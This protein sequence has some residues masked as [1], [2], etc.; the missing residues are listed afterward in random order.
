MANRRMISSSTWKDE[1]VGDLDFFQRCLWIGLF[2][3]CADDQGRLLDNS[4]LIRAELFPY[5]DIPAVQIEDGLAIFEKQG[6]ILRYSIKNKKYIQILKWWENQNP[7]WASRSKFPPPEG[8]MDKVRTRENGKYLVENWGS[9]GGMNDDSIS[10]Y[11]DVYKDSH[12]DTVLNQQ[13]PVPVPDPVKN[14]VPVPDVNKQEPCQNFYS[15]FSQ[16]LQIPLMGGKDLE[17]LQELQKQHGDEKLLKIATW[18][19]ER[20]PTI[21]SMW[22]ALRAIDTAAENW[23]DAPPKK[24]GNNNRKE[25]FEMLKEA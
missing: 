14:P 19:K 21:N 13:N 15:D 16:T 6:K 18:L 7:R 4:I 25:I 8:W 2:S 24:T 23:T 9:D 17:Y 20:D 5:D 10:S 12:E 1:F 3:S 11:E 22:K